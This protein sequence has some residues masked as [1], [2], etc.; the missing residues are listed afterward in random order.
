MQAILQFCSK[1][2]LHLISDEI[3]ALSTFDPGVTTDAVL[4]P[5]TSVLSVLDDSV[6]DPNSVHVLY[7]F[8]KVFL[9]SHILGLRI[10]FFF[11]FFFFFF[12]LGGN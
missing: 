10:S 6:I 2:N 5:F 9:L 12:F 4:T 3:Y 1:H 8:S 7:G 11:F